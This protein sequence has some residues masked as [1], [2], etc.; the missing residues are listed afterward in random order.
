MAKKSLM[1]RASAVVPR[2]GYDRRKANRISLW[3]VI[4][5]AIA[6]AAYIALELS[7]D[8]ASVSDEALTVRALFG[9]RVALSD[10]RELKLEKSP[11]ATGTRIF[12]DNAFGLFREG[13]FEVD[14]LGRARVFLKKPNVSYVTVRTEDKSYAVSLGS[15]EKDQLLY[16]RIKLGLK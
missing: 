3:V 9:F 11:V 1:R 2:R 13:D 14:G 16:D 6:F 4:V 7:T 12:G 15:L 5:V 10:I 8:P